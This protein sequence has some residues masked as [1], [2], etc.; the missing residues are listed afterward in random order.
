MDL[1]DERQ[2]PD[3]RLHRRYT[4]LSPEQLQTYLR[5]L[6]ARV[7]NVRFHVP[8]AQLLA[9]AERQMGRE[10]LSWSSLGGRYLE[11]VHHLTVD[12][13]L[14]PCGRQYDEPLCFQNPYQG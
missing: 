13:H 4:L 5:L 8:F 3:Q 1:N 6:E 12:T 2:E 14:L 11:A 10:S 7:D 9:F